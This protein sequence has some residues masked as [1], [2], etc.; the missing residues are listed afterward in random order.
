MG[1]I[2]PFGNNPFLKTHDDRFVSFI[3][4]AIVYIDDRLRFEWRPA[5]AAGHR[6]AVNMPL[7]MH[8]L[9]DHYRIDPQRLDSR[10]YRTYWH[11]VGRLEEVVNDRPRSLE[12]TDNNTERFIQ[13]F[14][15]WVL[16]TNRVIEEE[17]KPAFQ[18]GERGPLD[19]GRIGWDFLDE[20]QI[21]QHLLPPILHR[22]YSGATSALYDFRDW[23]VFGRPLDGHR[24]TATS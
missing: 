13:Q 15:D 24:F 3:T 2:L 9:L 8:Q 20:R 5:Q 22:L 10:L 6:P 14:T 4:D 18:R 11:I 23:K 16:L 17:W 1:I 12:S 21:R 7:L 19:V